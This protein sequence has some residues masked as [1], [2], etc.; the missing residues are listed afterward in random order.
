MLEC[1][2]KIFKVDNHKSKYFL[3]SVLVK[4]TLKWTPPK[5]P[6]LTPIILRIFYSNKRVKV[7]FQLEKR[8]F[9]NTN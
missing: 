3:P 7:S 2:F 8:Q 4:I 1:Q 5:N 6:S 9:R